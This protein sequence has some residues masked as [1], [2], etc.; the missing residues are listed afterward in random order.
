MINKNKMAKRKKDSIFRNTKKVRKW[1]FSQSPLL[2][3]TTY[4]SQRAWSS[5]EW[6]KP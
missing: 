1:K 4:R 5:P 3:L 6:M 2:G